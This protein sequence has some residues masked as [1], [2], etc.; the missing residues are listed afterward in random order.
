MDVLHNQ[1]VSGLGKDDVVF[2]IEDAGESTCLNIGNI[3]AH[4]SV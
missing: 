4:V 2:K 3:L 1:V